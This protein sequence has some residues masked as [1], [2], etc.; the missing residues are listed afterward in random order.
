MKTSIKT[1]IDAFR[2]YPRGTCVKILEQGAR[3]D[4][5]TVE[6]SPQVY[7]KLCVEY[8]DTFSGLS[9][10]KD[11]AFNE[12]GP[13]IGEMVVTFA[14]AVSTWAKAGFPIVESEEFERR[15]SVCR[16]CEYFDE[17]ARFGAGKCK[18]HG[19]GCTTLKLWL[20]TEDC[21]KKKW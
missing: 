3:C 2:H 5:D 12:A 20:Q 8:G 17:K 9:D 19:C 13:T 15:L 10:K 6:F 11:E 18:A 7:K 4:D 14:G 1:I 21:V 16:G